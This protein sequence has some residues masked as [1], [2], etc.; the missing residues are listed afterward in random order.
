MRCIAAHHRLA[1]DTVERLPG[2]DCP[3]FAAGNEWVMKFAPAHDAGALH[4][5]VAVQTTL[6]GSATPLRAAM[7]A[8]GTCEDWHYLVSSRLPGRPLHEVWPTLACSD[9]LVLA[10]EFGE[11]LRTLHEIPPPT[12]D[13]PDLPRWDVFV[14][15]AVHE[16]P[17]RWGLE[18][19]PA[20]L[21]ADGPR[22]LE[23]SGLESS[24][25]PSANLR[26]LHGDLAPEN[27]LVHENAGRWRFSGM[28]DFGNA[29]IGDRRFDYTAPTVLLAPGDPTIVRAFLRGAGVADGRIDP[30]LRRALMACTLVHPMADLHDCLALLP[31]TLACPTWDAVAER[32]WPDA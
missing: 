5:E 7:L 31:D 4:R 6:A 8:H 17:T 12:A 18:R 23:A 19:V 15:R 9:R 27:V 2:G 32:F 24:A 1:C 3:V 14:V 10:E 29:M 28:I 30:A 26:L 13:V 21:R 11:L 25:P 22:F 20:A 16:W